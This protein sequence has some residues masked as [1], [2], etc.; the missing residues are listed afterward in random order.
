MQP[1]WKPIVAGVL[2]IVSGVLNV[3][4]A[5]AFMLFMIVPSTYMGC[6]NMM[7]VFGVPF[8]GLG[9]VAIAGGISSLQ[10]RRWGF[11][12]AGCICAAISPW[13]L[14]GILAT[15][16]VALSRDEF[17]TSSSSST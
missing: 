1:T 14:L 6:P 12:L 2:A 3:L 11:A 15:V 8:I 5:L 4:I 9:A 17:P 10:R 16:F 13:M 7:M